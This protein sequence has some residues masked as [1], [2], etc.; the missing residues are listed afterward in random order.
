MLNNGQLEVPYVFKCA[1][2]QLENK[3]RGELLQQTSSPSSS[4]LKRPKIRHIT[5]TLKFLHPQAAGIPDPTGRHGRVQVVRRNIA[6]ANPLVPP[7]V[8]AARGRGF[9]SAPADPA[10]EFAPKPELGAARTPVQMP[11]LQRLL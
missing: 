2:C 4:K 6:L 5:M 1:I 7:Q 9:A 10:A 3:M 11:E 8:Q